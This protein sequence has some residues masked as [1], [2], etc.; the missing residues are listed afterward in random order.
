MLSLDDKSK[1]ILP[2]KLQKIT[3]RPCLV[4]DSDPQKATNSKEKKP[5]DKSSEIDSK[6]AKPDAKSPETTLKTPTTPKS[7]T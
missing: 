1:L 5:R 2:K 7:K 4:T 6:E 3:L